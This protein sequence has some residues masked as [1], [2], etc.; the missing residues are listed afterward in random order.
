MPG[1]I[2][3]RETLGTL[4]IGIDARAANRAVTIRA[5]KARDRPGADPIDGKK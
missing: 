5:T 1:S 2:A 3:S 4:S